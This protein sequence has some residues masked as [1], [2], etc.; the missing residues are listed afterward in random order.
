MTHTSQA[1]PGV[2]LPPLHAPPP[3]LPFSARFDQPGMEGRAGLFWRLQLAGWST[4]GVCIFFLTLETFGAPTAAFLGLVRAAFGLT[5]T[6]GLHALYRRL[7]LRRMRPWVLLPGVA[8]LCLILGATETALCKHFILLQPRSHVAPGILPLFERIGILARSG[9]FFG[10]SLLY[11][12]IRIWNDSIAARLHAAH[13]EAAASAAELRQLQAQV[14]PHFLFNALNSILAEKDDARSV[15]KIT[16]E[17]ADYL[18][19]A[20]RS[21]PDN[22]A[23]LGS[24]LD[25]LERYLRIEKSR[26]EERFTWRIEASPAARATPVPA[27]LVQPLLENAC[28]YGRHTSE[29]TLDVRISARLDNDALRI[30]VSN[31]GRWLAPGSAPPHGTGLGLANLRRRLELLSHGRARLDSGES[32][33]HVIVSVAWPLDCQRSESAPPGAKEAA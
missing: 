13:C 28:K 32:D 7:P 25:Q 18:R 14:N 12:I 11:F 17:L 31:T 23:P 19:H 27:A 33:G 1:S 8:A 20:L 3:P 22:C 30:A 21:T 16:G 6:T 5:I 26:F 29:H 15:E 10:W 24:E 2:M 4:V 9:S